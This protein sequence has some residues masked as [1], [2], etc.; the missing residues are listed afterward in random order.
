MNFRPERAQQVA[1]RLR[2]VEPEAARLLE[3]AIQDA[4]EQTDI[5]V[6]SDYEIPEFV[7]PVDEERSAHVAEYRPRWGR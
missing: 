6:H 3:D 2:L 4:L 1:A 7:L 5:E